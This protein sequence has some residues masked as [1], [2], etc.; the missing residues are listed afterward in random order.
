MYR[1]RTM[2]SLEH[3]IWETKEDLIAALKLETNPNEISEKA[4]KH[5]WNLVAQ[6]VINRIS[7]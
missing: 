4:K 6:R 1:P 2:S 7:R 5:S 3:I